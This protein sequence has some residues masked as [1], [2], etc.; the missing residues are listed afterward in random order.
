MT[1]LGVSSVRAPSLAGV[2]AGWRKAVL[3][4]AGFT[5]LGLVG[6]WEAASRPSP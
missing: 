6:L 3:A 5:F 4:V 1:W 2:A